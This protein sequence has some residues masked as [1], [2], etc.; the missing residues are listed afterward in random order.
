MNTDANSK[1][2]CQIRDKA[3]IESIQAH[4]HIFCTQERR[5]RCIGSVNLM[6]SVKRHQPIAGELR[7]VTA[8]SGQCGAHFEEELVEEKQDVVRKAPFA[9]ARRSPKIGK[10]HGHDLLHPGEP[11]PSAA[12][13]RSGGGQE[14][15]NDRK[16]GDR[17]NLACKPTVVGR[18]DTRQ[19]AGL[20]RCWRGQCVTTLQH[21]DP[22][23]RAARATAAYRG[24]GNVI[25][26]ESFEDRRA[27][28]DVNCATIGVSEQ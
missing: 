21:A 3:V 4:P 27:W 19:S 6:Q 26:I 11:G 24:V 23:G 5:T 9:Q 28:P 17:A 1:R 7:E 16:I 2:L 14:Q 25:L 18:A 13:D 12:V 22:A 10:H 20:K 8:G 15:R